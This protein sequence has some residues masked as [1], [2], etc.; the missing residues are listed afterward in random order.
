MFPR[1]IGAISLRQPILRNRSRNERPR[2]CGSVALIRKTSLYREQE[3]CCKVWAVGAEGSL[4]RDTLS[5]FGKFRIIIDSRSLAFAPLPVTSYNSEPQRA[6]PGN[7]SVVA[8]SL[9]LITVSVFP[10]LEMSV[11]V[12]RDQT[13]LSRCCCRTTV[14]STVPF[15]KMYSLKSSI[16]MTMLKKSI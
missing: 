9:K 6:P 5:R 16:R 13:K 7:Q 2:I 4:S 14:V 12:H 1:D 8:L 3:S 10:H 11:C 15:P